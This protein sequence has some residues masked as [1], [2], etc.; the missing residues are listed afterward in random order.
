MNVKH[1]IK[2]E[3]SH[4]DLVG[5]GVNICQLLVDRHGLAVLNGSLKHFLKALFST[6]HVLQVEQSH[7]YIQLL[8]LLPTE[9]T[10]KK[11]DYMQPSNHIHQ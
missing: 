4:L 5:F 2:G 8:L 11:R 6:V 3:E 10:K 7:P 9:T 1:Q